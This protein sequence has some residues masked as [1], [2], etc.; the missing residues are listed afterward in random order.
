MMLAVAARLVVLRLGFL[1]R[2]GRGLPVEVLEEEEASE[3]G[4]AGLLGPLPP[5]FRSLRTS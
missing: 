2:G 1:R 4:G 5:W 3:G